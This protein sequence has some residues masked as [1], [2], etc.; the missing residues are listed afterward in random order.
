IFKLNLIGTT[1]DYFGLFGFISKATIKNLTVTGNITGRSNVSGVVGY[2]E[3]NSV[4]TNVINKAKV[5][6]TSYLGGIAGQIRTGTNIEKS[7]NM[8]DIT[9][10]G[11][12]V[13][14][15]VG[16][17]FEGGA[18]DSISQSYNYGNITGHDRVGGIL[19]SSGNIDINDVYSRGTIIGN[20]YYIGGIVGYFGSGGNTSRLTNSYSAS[21]V[22]GL[23]YVGGI[24][25]HNNISTSYVNNSYYDISLIDSSLAPSGL[26]APTG[27]IRN[28]N[29]ATVKGLD[30]SEMVGTQA[31]INTFITFDKSKWVGLDSEGDYSYYPQ[32][33]H[34][35]D[36]E[37]YVRDNSLQSVT[38]SI[39]AGSGTE[40]DPFQ[41][42]TK[43][44]MKTLS[45]YIQRG[46]ETKDLY[47]AVFNSFGYIDLTDP[48]LGY[49]PIGDQD[50]R[51][52]GNFNGNYV[53]FILNLNG[54]DYYGLFG[55]IG[56]D[57]VVHSVSTSG[58][59]T[60]NNYVGSI[61]GVNR[62]IVREVYSTTLINAK[63]YV[64]GLVGINHGTVE[65][66]YYISSKINA[67]NYVGGITG[68]N[69]LY[70]YDAYAATVVD[71]STYIGGVSGNSNGVVDYA[72]Y[73][74]AIT[75]LSKSVIKNRPTNA[76]G[77]IADSTYVR[78][79]GTEEMT[80]DSL[81]LMNFQNSW[82][83]T[84]NN[85]L[86]SFYL[87]INGFAN[88]IN[89]NIKN[90]SI[91]SV[92]R[93][94]FSI[95]TGTEEDPFIIRNASDMVS[96][97]EIVASRYNFSG[98]FVKVLEGVNEINLT[99]SELGFKSIG[100]Y[101]TSS[102]GSSFGFNGDFDGSNTKIIV[103]FTNSNVSSV[104]LF[105][106][107]GTGSYVHDFFIAG[108][109]N[110]HDFVGSVVSFATNSKLENIYNIGT[111]ELIDGVL[112]SSIVTG[113]N[114][115][116]G[117]AGRLVDSVIINSYNMSNVQS[118]GSSVAGISGYSIRTNFE[119][120]FNYG[121]ISGTSN[122][123]GIIGYADNTNVFH[124]YNRSSVIGSNNY[125][126]GIIGRFNVGILED[127]YS[128][129]VTRGSNINDVGG[130][131]GYVNG[132]TIENNSYYDLSTIE[133]DQTIVGVTPIRS[134]GNK[135]D[136]WENNTLIGFEKDILTGLKSVK[137]KLNS[138]YW[139]FIENDGVDA[140]YPQ[141]KV[142]A[143][144]E[145]NKVKEDSLSSV[146]SYIFAGSGLENSPYI[147]VNEHDMKIL[148]ELVLSGIDFENAYFKV[149]NNLATFDMTKTGLNYAPIG[150]VHYPFNGNFNGNGA[151]FK[152]HFDNLDDSYLGLFGYLGSKA[153]VY[154][155][156]ISGDINGKDYLGSVAG[157][158][159][160]VIH[161]VYS[162]ANITGSNYLGGIAG[163]NTNNINTAYYIG[164][165]R[166]LS[167]IGGITGYHVGDIDDTYVV[168]IMY[169]DNKLGAIL[170]YMGSEA[171]II[172]SYY[173]IDIL[174]NA[175]EDSYGQ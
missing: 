13:G 96:L 45:L 164:D 144:N 94:R 28:S 154:Q 8:A 135:L 123:G 103:N 74:K 174:N 15:I 117:I 32:L 160:G 4:I 132:I 2:A 66:G 169:G 126:G 27:A 49:I 165:M 163:Y 23:N 130:V 134:V 1:S 119:N 151:D 54:Q 153:T 108:V 166:G 173:N 104:G 139:V 53:N 150:T 33:Q 107:L 131:V 75:D 105:S 14:G 30:R 149:R 35:V 102:P 56:V 57:G 147:I 29:T 81:P 63:D 97:S 83:T 22:Y 141:L 42:R 41:I 47:F 18:R 133:A 64:G 78:G 84:A 25:G 11:S 85:G 116:G 60:A 89:S 51:F 171:S 124:A 39:F 114:N 19:G 62:G 77:N 46:N 52:N 26:T 129:G 122:I 10:T 136:D 111:D 95:G 120:I 170:G 137:L 71:G 152:L 86:F 37:G 92:K 44:D 158:N 167:Y 161:T 80:A 7:Y 17:N 9:A 110:G 24:I 143:Q 34:F 145:L 72:Y 175:S 48:G 90:A 109:V 159:D 101:N 99:S 65:Y 31:L 58:D 20:R 38:I 55:H 157:V 148:S 172:N 73:N 142:F 115:V 50:N 12:Y 87:Q 118:R 91:E 40:S 93:I 67:S 162:T 59:V 79:L 146:K 113:R 3:S 68:D 112:T 88:N 100:T 36:I 121:E 98:Q 16:Y 70:L 43:Y 6:G 155:L 21:Y 125:V 127:S 156:S 61:A 138:D 76:I 128:S 106:Y 5:T 168:S 82:F 140:Y 69:K